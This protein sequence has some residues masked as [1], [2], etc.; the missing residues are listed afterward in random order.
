M[1]VF[2]F[3]YNRKPRKFNYTPILYNPEEEERKKKLQAR[4]EKVKREMGV[5]PEEKAPEKKDFKTEF[6][7]QTRHLKKRK[8]RESDGGNPFFVNNG[9]LIII[10]AVLFAVFFFWFYVR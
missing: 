8:E 3:Y 4:I 9:W 1:G 10:L 2:F 7:S 5:L 6:V